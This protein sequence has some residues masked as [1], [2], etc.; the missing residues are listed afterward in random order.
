M[1]KLLIML[2]RLPSRSILAF[3]VVLI[4][5]CST[6]L[7]TAQ[8]EDPL[9]DN[10]ADPVKLF[11]KAQT[12]HARGE[13]ERALSY[14]Q[15]AI[16]IRPEF[17][18][19]E[20]QLGNVLV[21][22]GRLTE[23][24]S[25]FRQAI[26][27]RKN[28]SLP[29]SALGALLARGN[30]ESD[31]TPLLREALK[32]DKS[33]NLALRVLANLRL[34]AGDVKEALTLAQAATNDPEASP[35][36]WLM[37]AITE[38]ANSDKIAARASLQRV[39]QS[40][41]EN[42]DARLERAELYVDDGDYEKALKDLAAVEQLKVS[43]KQVL[44]RIAV[45]YERAGKADDARRVAEHGGLIQPEDKSAD[46]KA[47]VIGTPEEI[48]AAN[49]E[50]PGVARKALEKLLGKNPRSA[51]LLARLGASFRTDDPK[52]SQ[53]YYRRAAELQ[54]D[55]PEYAT[56]YA[57][58]L[59]RHRRFGEAAG[60]LRRVIAIA[61]EN[62]TAHANLA[63]AL[64]EL[65]RFAEAIEEFEWLLKARPD[66]AVA[67]YFVGSARDNLGEYRDALVA[68][69]AFLSRAEAKTNQLEIDKVN[70]RLPL[71]RRQIQI[72]QGVKRKQ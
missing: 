16:K 21:S 52:R 29:Y 8:T 25:A 51:M 69:E 67:Y 6:A 40:E 41:P 17:P 50:D 10:A 22:L 68:Y 26:K 43:D 57:A 38:R 32:L 61:P 20:F 66:L 47:R 36:T 35:S 45:A 65:K 56:G 4:V 39:L 48:E 49:N 28:W 71:L 2:F 33:D 19:A 37:R 34:R 70:L 11:E 9:G 44:S 27:L 14:Y 53:D 15:E 7:V 63:T 12:A 31:A 46:G 13:L 18:E 24:E 72:G 60:I 23:A 1:R 30:R 3:F 5:A 58:A 59:L 62:Y 55:N 54:P 42:V 64:Y